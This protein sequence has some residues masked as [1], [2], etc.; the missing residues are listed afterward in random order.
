MLHKPD[1]VEKY[2]PYAII[3]TLKK[4]VIYRNR[5]PPCLSVY[6]RKSSL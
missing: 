3:G 4:W 2:A 5:F 6:P 1:V